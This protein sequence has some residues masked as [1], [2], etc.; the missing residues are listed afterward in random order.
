MFTLTL[1]TGHF[2][3]IL[4]PL[5]IGYLAQT[6]DEAISSLKMIRIVEQWKKVWL[7]TP[8]SRCFLTQWSGVKRSPQFKILMME[9]IWYS[10]SCISPAATLDTIE[11]NLRYRSK[12]EDF[13]SNI[14]MR[15]KLRDIVI[16][17]SVKSVKYFE[18]AIKNKYYN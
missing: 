18:N 12:G 2:I 14:Q 7:E 5:E 11:E 3:L 6:V 4:L 10:P 17:V 8:P 15:G 9:L 16:M 13:Q 1:K